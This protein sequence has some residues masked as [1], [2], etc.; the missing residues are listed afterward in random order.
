MLEQ[1]YSALQGKGKKKKGKDIPI[2]GLGGP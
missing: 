2:T 1:N